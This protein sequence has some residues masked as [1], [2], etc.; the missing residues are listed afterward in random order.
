M[1]DKRH[2]QYERLLT[3]FQVTIK[4]SKYWKQ[5][6]IMNKSTSL[7]TTHILC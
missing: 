4:Y 6:K 5:R 1:I 7:A 2:V 3:E